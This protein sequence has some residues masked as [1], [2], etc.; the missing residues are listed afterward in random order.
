LETVRSATLEIEARRVS[1]ETVRRFLIKPMGH[2][3]LGQGRAGGIQDPRQIA[4]GKTFQKRIDQ[5]SE[6]HRNTAAQPNRLEL[7]VDPTVFFLEPPVAV[8]PP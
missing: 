6:K 1:F 2:L 8:K 3:P 5:P 4:F 7:Y